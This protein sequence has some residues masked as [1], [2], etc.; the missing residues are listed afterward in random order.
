MAW[1]R[2]R[3]EE[4]PPSRLADRL[5]VAPANRWRAW[6]V[7]A[8]LWS[9]VVLGAFGG[10]VGL[11]RSPADEQSLS[12]EDASSNERAPA[13]VLGVGEWAVRVTLSADDVAT[14][15]EVVAVPVNRD[16]AGTEAVRVLSAT[17]IAAVRV[18]DDYWAVTVAAQ[19]D[20]GSGSV[21]RWYLE[22]GVLESGGGA[23]A[24]SE[25]ALVAPPPSA[26]GAAEVVGTVRAPD[27]SDP[28]MEAAASFLTALL[29]GDPAVG[30]WTAPGFEVSP[31]A[32]E[33]TFA[34]IRVD[35]ASIEA[36]DTE[37][38][39]IRAEVSATT[40]GDVIVAL[41]Y[42][43]V[44]TERGD[45]WEVTAVTGAPT[46]RSRGKPEP[47]TPGALPASTPST[48][49]TSTQPS[50]TTAPVA[51]TEGTNPNPYLY[52]EEEN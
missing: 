35:R 13:A 28:P 20:V 31:A 27:L 23:V 51:P 5:T 25:P 36:I 50:P 46:L 44:V 16:R 32:T 9:L 43:I 11:L 17:A 29:S 3:T 42:E 40:A 39:R 1:K 26:V 15:R 37:T 6:S 2:T 48:T 24:V 7:T 22:V 12:S 52:E 30:R 45:R 41:A 47:S 4:V 38:R 33:G 8:G 10:A 21:A 34:R 18:G 19:V 14:A 49:T